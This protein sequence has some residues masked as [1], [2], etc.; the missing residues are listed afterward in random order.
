MAMLVPKYVE[1]CESTVT[2]M[3]KYIW[4]GYLLKCPVHSVVYRSR[5]LWSGNPPP[6]DT[7]NIHFQVVHVWP[8]EKSLLQVG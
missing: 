7:P 5:A 8:G 1:D 2:G 6:E 4:A 3:M